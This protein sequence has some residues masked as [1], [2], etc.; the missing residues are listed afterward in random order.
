M[1]RVD[2]DKARN[3]EVRVW[4]EYDRILEKMEG[5]PVNIKFVE[6]FEFYEQSKK[7]YAVIITG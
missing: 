7:S 6:R 4:K 3:L 1:D 2:S 5:K